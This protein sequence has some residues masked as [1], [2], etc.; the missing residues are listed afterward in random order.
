M[1][2][3]YLDIIFG[4][5]RLNKSIADTINIE[6]EKAGISDINN[7]QALLLYHIGDKVL[8]IGEL[9]SRGY[10]LGTNISY[11]LKKLV[12]YGYLEQN[13]ASFDKRS[14]LIKLT[15]KG[16]K[17]YQKLDEIFEKHSEFIKSNKLDVDKATKVFRDLEV[18]FRKLILQRTRGIHESEEGI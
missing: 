18:F 16:N 13:I 1:K 10:Y 15:D 8:S 11:N 12:N 3:R 4:I 5:E 2:K 7:I 9:I 17:I 14:S 6:L